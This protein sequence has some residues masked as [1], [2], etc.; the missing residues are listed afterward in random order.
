LNLHLRD[1]QERP[2]VADM[3][4]A[5][6]PLARSGQARGIGDLEYAGMQDNAVPQSLQGLRRVSCTMSEYARPAHRYEY[7]RRTHFH[8]I[9]KVVGG[10]DVIRVL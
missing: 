3:H 1:A 9:G 5:A 2:E 4:T 10:L 8:G 6:P 7:W